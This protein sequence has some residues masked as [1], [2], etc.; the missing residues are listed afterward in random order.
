M[1]PDAYSE[2][3]N[4]TKNTVFIFI[5]LFEKQK[6]KTACRTGPY[7]FQLCSYKFRNT[8][9]HFRIQVSKQLYNSFLFLKTKK[10]NSFGKWFQTRVQKLNSTFWGRACANSTTLISLVLIAPKMEF[11]QKYP[12]A[13]FLFSWVSFTFF[14]L[15]PK[16][17][18][19]ELQWRCHR[20]P[21]S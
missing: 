7:Y 4:E 16:P 8:V 11:G 20:R 14:F 19:M 13:S 21:T 1:L 5:F 17:P 2:F 9:F 15:F 18:L 3:K 10:K 12:P 6:Q